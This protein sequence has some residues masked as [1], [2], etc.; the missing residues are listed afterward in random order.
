MGAKNTERRKS[1]A[2]RPPSQDSIAV[3]I[4]DLKLASLPGSLEK[5][6]Y[7]VSLSLPVLLVVYLQVAQQFGILGG[8]SDR[9][10]ILPIYCIFRD[11][12]QVSLPN[13]N[14]FLILSSSLLSPFCLGCVSS[15]N[16]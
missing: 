13:L 14:H 6:E 9:Q 2:Q 15:M 1:T 12:D 11:Y 7:Q 5:P 4:E 8:M 16:N 3:L 10:H